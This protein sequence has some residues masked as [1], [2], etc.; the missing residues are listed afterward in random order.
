[1]TEIN[2]HTYSKTSFDDYKVRY[3]FTFSTDDTD[4]T[5]NQDIYSTCLDK[6]EVY[7]VISKRMHSKVY[8]LEIYHTATKEQDDLDVPAFLRKKI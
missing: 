1:M 6:N 3:K 7:M 4:Y 2:G 8:N 5:H